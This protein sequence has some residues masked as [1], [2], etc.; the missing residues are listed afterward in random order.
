MK[1]VSEFGCQII[2]VVCGTETTCEEEYRLTFTAPVF[3]MKLDTININKTDI[4]QS[5]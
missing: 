3:V 5:S 4:A 2:K 1:A